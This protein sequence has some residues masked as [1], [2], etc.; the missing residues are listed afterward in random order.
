VNYSIE[1]LLVVV[2]FNLLVR[3][4]AP[5]VQLYAARLQR[6]VEYCAS[7]GGRGAQQFRGSPRRLSVHELSTAFEELD[8]AFVFHR[9]RARAK[10]AQIPALPGLRILL[11][12]V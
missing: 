9:R 10:G 4:E 8:G 1:L 11:P 12:R 6:L 3:T 2:S 5:S 7:F